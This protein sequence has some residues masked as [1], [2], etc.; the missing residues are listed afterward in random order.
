[1]KQNSLLRIKDWDPRQLLV[2]PE[3]GPF[4]AAARRGGGAAGRRVMERACLDTEGQEEA[5]AERAG[6][7]RLNGLRKPLTRIHFPQ[8]LL[9]V[10]SD[11][12]A[13]GSGGKEAF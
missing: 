13:V 12:K 2:P 8:E 3:V 7:S 6:S 5:K 1:M 10:Q 4:E 9:P 11:R